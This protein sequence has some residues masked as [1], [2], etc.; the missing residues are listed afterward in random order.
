M[1]VSFCTYSEDG[2]NEIDRVHA[3]SSGVVLRE[4]QIESFWRAQIF[5]RFQIVHSFAL[6]LP[7]L[8]NVC[9]NLVGPPRR[10]F[11]PRVSSNARR[12]RCRPRRL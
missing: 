9:L 11:Q 4:S 8:G 12:L 7:A 3:R 2:E 10:F 6:P 1:G 5:R